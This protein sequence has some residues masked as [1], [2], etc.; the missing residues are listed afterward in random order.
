MF[1]TAHDGVKLFYE[2]KGSGPILI[3]V[4]GWA[5]NHSFFQAQID[6]FSKDYRVI[7]PDL[8]GHGQSETVVPGCSMSIPNLANDLNDLIVH[9]GA[10]KVTLLGWSLGVLI[11]Y[12]YIQQFGCDAIEK[13]ILV[14][15]S[16]KTSNDP[17]WDYGQARTETYKDVIGWLSFYAFNWAEAVPTFVPG[18]F[19]NG[20]PTADQWPLADWCVSQILRTRS[21]NLPYLN[22]SMAVTDLREVL[23]TITVPT[24]LIHGAQSVMFGSHGAYLVTLIPGAQLAM[25]PGGHIMFMEHPEEFNVRVRAF[26]S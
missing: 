14:D 20:K 11:S 7:A 4:H 26:L 23:P 3:M 10:G 24:L 2:E 16:P 22:I 15:M 18:M 6:E 21:D 17:G 25:L 8:R 5:C 9:L 13:L 19:G 1:F 12:S